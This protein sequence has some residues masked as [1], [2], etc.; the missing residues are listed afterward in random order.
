MPPSSSTPSPPH[1]FTSSPL[2]LLTPSPPHSFTSSPTQAPH[3]CTWIR[4]I[5]IR[6]LQPYPAASFPNWL[7]AA[8][9]S[10]QRL[11]AGRKFSAEISPSSAHQYP[12]G[13]NTI[14]F[15][16]LATQF[17]GK[18]LCSLRTL[19]TAELQT[20]PLRQNG[21]AAE[22]RLNLHPCS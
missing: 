8:A 4:K 20:R 7:R 11:P 17:Q 21:G 14:K 1:P 10:R 22:Q 16:P 12:R 15:N 13:R 3:L 19:N 6:P 9:Q 2:H 18:N 5:Q